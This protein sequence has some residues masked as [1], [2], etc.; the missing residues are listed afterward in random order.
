MVAVLTSC[1][2][3]A[4]DPDPVIPLRLLVLATKRSPPQACPSTR[5]TNETCQLSELLA[6][7]PRAATRRVPSADA[8]AVHPSSP[9]P[10]R[11]CFAP[12]VRL[13]PQEER[14]RH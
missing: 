4:Q 6:P 11:P 14:P 8:C 12:S 10:S 3:C 9:P 1:T 7:E 5:S 2:L 13:S